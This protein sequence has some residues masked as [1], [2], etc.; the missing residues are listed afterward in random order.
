MADLK[1]LNQ[2]VSCGSLCRLILKQEFGLSF[3]ERS[4]IMKV[5]PVEESDYKRPGL[6]L[7]GRLTESI[8]EEDPLYTLENIGMIE[9]APN[10]L[11]SYTVLVRHSQIEKCD[12]LKAHKTYK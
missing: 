4:K 9:N 2:E 7:I 12:I 5:K 3:N 11:V 6:K 8:R 10:N 1:N